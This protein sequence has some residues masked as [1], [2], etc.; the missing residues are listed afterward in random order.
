MKKGEEYLVIFRILDS[1]KN[2]KLINK[3]IKDA[4]KTVSFLR[5]AYARK[6]MFIAVV[7][8]PRKVITFLT[9]RDL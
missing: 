8:K 7:Q 1:D 2:V 6:I 5:K 4:E 3:T 9:W